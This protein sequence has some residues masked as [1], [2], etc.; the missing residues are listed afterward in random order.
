MPEGL[1]VRGRSNWQLANKQLAEI[2]KKSWQLVNR[3][4]AEIQKNKLIRNIVKANGNIS[5]LDSIL[6][7]ANYNY[8]VRI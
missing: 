2:H 6:A 5:G 7:I 8:E 4:L 1:E 3:Q